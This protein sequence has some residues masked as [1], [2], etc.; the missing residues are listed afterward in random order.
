[1]KIYMKIICIIVFSFL[2]CLCVNS[3]VYAIE[4]ITITSD[5]SSTSEI[6]KVRKNNSGTD[7]ENCEYIFGDPDDEST[8]AYMLQ[9]VF[10]Y[11]KVLGP[12]LVILLSGI[13]FAKNALSPD[14]DGMKK[15]TNKL[16]VRLLCAIGVFFIPMLASWILALV[17]NGSGS[18]GIS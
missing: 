15:I 17:N 10:D 5:N 14:A 11:L 4:D 12:I 6:V 13:D 7:Q 2:F 3:N 1:M 9:K 18:C 16:L 8:V